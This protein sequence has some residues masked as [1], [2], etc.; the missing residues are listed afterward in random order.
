MYCP[1]KKTANFINVIRPQVLD[2][3][4]SIINVPV[5]HASPEKWS[6]IKNDG[7]YRDKKGQ[8]QRPMIIFTRSSMS[9]DDSF[10]HFNKSCIIMN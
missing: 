8:I 7:V 5:R 4:G 1:I 9:R 2:T 10:I 6:A 3:H